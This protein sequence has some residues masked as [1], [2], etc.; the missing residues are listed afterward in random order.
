MEIVY[1]VKKNAL[2]KKLIVAQMT[3]VLIFHLNVLQIP[4]PPPYRLPHLMEAVVAT[5][6]IPP[7]VKTILKEVTVLMVF[8]ILTVV[9]GVV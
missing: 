8:L 2:F 1:R 7:G 4:R 6:T 9:V 5:Q 3:S